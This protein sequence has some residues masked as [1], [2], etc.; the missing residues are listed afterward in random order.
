M[1][2]SNIINHYKILFIQNYAIFIKKV[3]FMNEIENLIN[4]CNRF[5]DRKYDLYEFQSRLETFAIS[6]N[7][8]YQLAKTIDE[9]IN[10]LEEIAFT[11]KEENF[12]KYGV[13]VANKLI[14]EVKK[15]NKT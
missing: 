9:S 14:Y 11:S 10:Q 5:L 2:T 8:C 4:I 13:S 1:I 15:K 3:E 7:Q 12:Y 6:D